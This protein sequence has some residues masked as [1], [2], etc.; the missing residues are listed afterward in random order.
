MQIT[1][2]D[3]YW[4]ERASIYLIE[5]DEIPGKEEVAIDWRSLSIELE[6]VSDLQVRR[7]AVDRLRAMKPTYLQNL[8][9]R[10]FPYLKEVMCRIRDQAKQMSLAQ[11]LERSDGG[12]NVFVKSLR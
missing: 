10:V 12:I 7:R 6:S 5:I 4:R 3:S 2:P 1:L 9:K 11:R 8:E